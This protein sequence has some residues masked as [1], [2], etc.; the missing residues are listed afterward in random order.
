[1][2]RN[3]TDCCFCHGAREETRDEVRSGGQRA[4]STSWSKSNAGADSQI[5]SVESAD[6]T[7]GLRDS[8]DPLASLPATESAYLERS[9]FAD[10]AEHFQSDLLSSYPAA[11][12]LDSKA[13]LIQYSFTCY[14]CTSPHTN[15]YALSTH[16]PLLGAE[17]FNPD[18]CFHQ[19]PQVPRAQCCTRARTW[20]PRRTCLEGG[21]WR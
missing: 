4:S 12:S 2:V 11:A 3:V 16:P 19:R 6:A 5:C 18:T 1:M 20:G 14:S 7:R 9:P 13:S 17:S 8:C 10:F 21:S 15:P